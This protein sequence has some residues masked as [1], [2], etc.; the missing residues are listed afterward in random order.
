[1]TESA[2]REAEQTYR[3]LV[4]G[5]P[6]VV[7]SAEL[8]RG[9]D[10]LYV[11]PRAESVFGY[12]SE[13][14]F[15]DPFLWERKVHPDDLAGVLR[16]V[17]RCAV[18]GERFLA[19]YRFATA[20]G[21]ERWVRDEASIDLPRTPGGPSVLRGVMYDVT[22]QKVAE[23]RLREA[24][25]REQAV[26]RHLRE[27]DDMKNSI[28]NAVSHELR[29]PLT[30]ILGM[31]RLLQDQRHAMSEVDADRF[32]ERIGINAER[33]S[34]LISDLLDLDRLSRGILEP[35]RQAIDV[36]QA[37]GRVLGEIPLDGRPVSVDVEAVTA[38]LDPA[39]FERIVVNL[40]TNATRYTPEGTPIWLVVSGRH[41][42]ILI[43]VE[44]A[45]PGV[46]EHLRTSIFDPFR[47]GDQRIDHSPGVGIGL[48]LVA[49]FAALHGGRAWVE[50]RPGGGA[51][52][53]VFLASERVRAVL[54]ALRA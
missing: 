48:S 9:G 52:F 54:T 36:A 26:S 29:T 2:L 37:V 34:R 42:G 5:L 7:Y 41:D 17:E 38:E 30:S 25:E 21:V 50:D 32:V 19:E 33:L 45:G 47:Q 8:G 46:P 4:E 39:Q 15:R 35:N 24:V 31:T 44:D 22:D 40:V 16:S 28:L 18:T 12:T 20:D 51:S 49:K 23:Q 53:H 43:V 3:T 13:E 27:L 11:S 10:W 1:M 6:A 14:W